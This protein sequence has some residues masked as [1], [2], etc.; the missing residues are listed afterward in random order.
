MGTFEDFLIKCVEKDQEKLEK[1]ERLTATDCTHCF[2]IRGRTMIDLVHP[3][4]G[5]TLIFGKT[6]ADC[7]A[8][9]GYELAE[10]MTVEEFRKSKAALQDTPI[11]WAEVTEEKYN[12][13]LDVL[14]PALWLAGGFLVGEPWDHHPLTGYPRFAAYREQGG[15]F[16][17]ANRPMTRTEFKVA[18]A[19]RI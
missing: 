13:W 19:A 5:L 18:L 11:Q 2:A 9:K 8:E 10:L 6:L 12:E 16:Y 15:K 14:P 17:T 7:Q 3:A 1:L 4:T